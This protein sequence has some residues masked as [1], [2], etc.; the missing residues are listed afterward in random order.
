M[1]HFNEVFELEGAR[2]RMLLRVPE[3]KRAWVISTEEALAWPFELS[4]PFIDEQVA[5]DVP[6]AVRSGLTPK[7]EA[8]RDKAWVIL[9][10]LLDAHPAPSLF[11]PS[12]RKA[13]IAQLIELLNRENREGAALGFEPKATCTAPT[14]YK[15]LRRYWQRGNT[16]AALVPDYLNS[17]HSRGAAGPEKTGFTAGRGRPGR[18]PTFQM[19]PVHQANIRKAIEETVAVN[20]K[21]KLPA[22]MAY[23]A[24]NF[25]NGS[26]GNDEVVV[27]GRGDRPSLAQVR[28][29]YEQN[30]DKP[31]RVTHSV[32]DDLYHQR[33]RPE[34]GSAIHGVH[35]PGHRYEVD[36]T[37]ME[38]H[39]VTK[40][41]RARTMKKLTL[42]VVVD[43]WSRLIVGYY[44]GFE[45]ASWIGAAMAILN[46]FEDKEKMCQRYGVKY[47]PEEWP[48]DECVP[49]DWWVD[50]GPEWKGEQSKK[51]LDGIWGNIAN[52]PPNRPEIKNFVENSFRLIN[53]KHYQ[54]E[55]S[56]DPDVNRAKRQQIDY[57]KHA[58][59]NVDEL[60]KYVLETIIRLNRNTYAEFPMWA[61]MVSKKIKP[62]PINL[63]NFGIREYGRRPRFTEDQVRLALLPEGTAKVKQTGIHFKGSV[64]W[65]QPAE[66]AKWFDIAHNHTFPVEVNYDPRT[67]NAIYVFPRDKGRKGTPHVA[68]LSNRNAK[69]F[70][71]NYHSEVELLIDLKKEIA[72]QAEQDNLQEE[73]RY[74]R[75][76]KPTADNAY[77]E[78]K[79]QTRGVSKA[80]RTKN[81][82]ADRLEA[83]AN[84][85]RERPMVVELDS[86]T[87]L[88]RGAFTVTTQQ[89]PETRSVAPAP[90][91]GALRDVRQ[92]SDAP[93]VAA[94]GISANQS[95]LQKGAMSLKERTAAFRRSLLNPASTDEEP[96]P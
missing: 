49:G 27:D 64:Y 59:G 25:Y 4:L 72:D 12:V 70:E 34:T 65:S 90:G 30:Y 74:L 41:S 55:R 77:K 88:S 95:R 82:V 38:V 47:D 17:G 83:L 69:G 40:T 51:M 29:F 68:R 36:A 62:T 43:R 9:Q 20:R 14:L 33:H 60:N 50:N 75:R 22:V 54:F 46:I 3:S 53:L 66:D 84:E 63:W 15:W 18:L 37:I 23:L 94:P 32:G 35:G 56:S 21:V 86:Q 67:N 79:E 85:R 7:E 2:F 89:P 26:D 39:V 57:Q 16:F 73:V 76:V 91:A 58:S 31:T 93:A 80:S 81:R 52:L 87:R 6:L 78:M 45:H 13:A 71:D 42:Y 1:I 8:L 96:T 28:Y 92:G 10:R 5:L 44:L 11:L 61:E 48:A 24:N 19:T